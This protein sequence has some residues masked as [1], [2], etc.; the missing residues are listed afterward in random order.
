M[1][2]IFIIQW[3][4]LT[5]INRNTVPD[6]CQHMSH[7]QK[8]RNICGSYK[9]H[10][11]YTWC[12]TIFLQIFTF[13]SI[14][15]SLYRTII[16][17]FLVSLEIAFISATFSIAWLCSRPHCRYS[18]KGTSIV[19][20]CNSPQSRE[21]LKEWCIYGFCRLWPRIAPFLKGFQWLWESTTFNHSGPLKSLCVY[22]S[23]RVKHPSGR[24]GTV[25][26]F[27]HSLIFYLFQ[28][29]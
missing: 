6:M 27:L 1:H 2:G 17:F 21:S 24:A 26:D 29:E 12:N 9:W 23:F 5:W 14:C 7:V 10:R 13:I 4:V 19:K 15:K 8:S 20:Y 22:E 25:S 18:L 28:W 11:L 3:N 16:F